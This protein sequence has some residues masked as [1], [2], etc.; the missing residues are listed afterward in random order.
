MSS[1]NSTQM[2]TLM[3]LCSGLLFGIGLTVSDMINPA[4]VLGFLDV[5]GSWDPTLAFVMG[6][7]LLIT[8]PAFAL[9]GK[10]HK[11]VCA[12]KFQLPA[13]RMIDKPLVVG[14]VLFGIGWGLVGFCP[15][16]ALASL[17]TL[18]GDVV[19]FVASMVAGMGL[20]QWW[21]KQ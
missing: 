1:Q 9:V 6:G 13:N 5:A 12:D 2:V 11:P 15:G 18:R 16:P 20:F 14:A 3:A 21:D 8:F 4:R 19:L 7:A 10:L 17:V